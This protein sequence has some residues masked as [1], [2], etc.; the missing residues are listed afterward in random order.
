MTKGKKSQ[1]YYD[2]IRDV[3]DRVCANDASPDEAAIAELFLKKMEQLD[4]FEIPDDLPLRKDKKG[5]DPQASSAVP[6]D[7]SW[8]DGGASYPKVSSRVGKTYQATHLPR[9]GSF[10]SKDM[11][12]DPDLQ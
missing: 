10:T 12:L 6:V 2:R 1:D 11:K 9:A 4:E 7:L 8:K 5:S 3:I